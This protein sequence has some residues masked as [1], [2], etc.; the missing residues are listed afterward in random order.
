M[1]VAGFD[2]AETEVLGLDTVALDGCLRSG[3]ALDEDLETCLDSELLIADVFCLDDCEAETVVLVP[4]VVCLEDDTDLDALEPDAVL[5][6]C[7][8]ALD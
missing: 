6:V 8:K 7:A 3:V 4:D 5:L 2:G 1:W